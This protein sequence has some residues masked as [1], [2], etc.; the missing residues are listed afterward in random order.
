VPHSFAYFANEWGFFQIRRVA[1][2]SALPESETCSQI[3]QDR[4]AQTHNKEI[5]IHLTN[6]LTDHIIPIIIV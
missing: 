4:E 5:P 1:R 2:I 3:R 6:V